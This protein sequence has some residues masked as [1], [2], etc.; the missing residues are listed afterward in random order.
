MADQ[1]LDYQ[2]FVEAVRK[3]PLEQRLMLMEELSRSVRSDLSPAPS[4]RSSVKEMR[5][6]LKPEGDVPS[7]EDFSDAYTRYLIEKYT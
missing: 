3:L 4:Q 7:D 6:I 2:D 5:G 1:K